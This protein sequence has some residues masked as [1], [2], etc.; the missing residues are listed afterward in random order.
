MLKYV[1]ESTSTALWG[2][3]KVKFTESPTYINK[4]SGIKFNPE[5]EIVFWERTELLNKNTK[6]RN[7]DLK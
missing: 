3:P 1:K 2:L 4:E 5:V 7:K 6:T